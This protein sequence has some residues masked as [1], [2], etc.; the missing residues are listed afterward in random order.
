MTSLNTYIYFIYRKF[1]F[2]ESKTQKS[3]GKS[4][5][6]PQ[7]LETE[8]FQRE[9]RSKETPEKVGV[10]QPPSPP[11]SKELPQ[12][13]AQMEEL[14]YMSTTEMY[15]CRWHQPPPSPLREPS[16][17]KEEVVASKSFTVFTVDGN[18]LASSS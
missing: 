13:S 1:C 7:K 10:G 18:Q 5:F 14:P 3:R 17:K 15:L 6:S 16:P 8:G 12:S 2:L 11:Q 9:L 4:K